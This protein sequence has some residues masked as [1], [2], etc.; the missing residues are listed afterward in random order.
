VLLQFRLGERLLDVR[1]GR[2]GAF[3][4]FAGRRMFLLRGE[5]AVELLAEPPRLRRR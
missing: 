5:L 2:L 3:G 1:R 4:S